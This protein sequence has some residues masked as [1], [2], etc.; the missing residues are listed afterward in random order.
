[1]RCDGGG[2]GLS[3]TTSAAPAST[4][5][6]TAAAATAA[7]GV[8]LLGGSSGAAGDGCHGDRE[9]DNSER[10]MNESANDARI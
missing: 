3:A 10:A 1:L 8:G 9:N 2:H 4:T 5:T 6:T 7:T